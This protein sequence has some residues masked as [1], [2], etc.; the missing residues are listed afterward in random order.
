M[1]I[2]ET[3]DAGRKWLFQTGGI[4]A[5]ALAI[6]YLVIMALYVPIGAPPGG[7][8]ARLAYFARNTAAWWGI[9]GLSVFTDFLFVPVGLSLYAALKG[10]NRNAM[11]LAMAC[12]ALFVFLDLAIT[13]INYG[14]MIALSGDYAKAATDEQR[15]AILPAASYPAAVL[16][17]S[18]LFVYNTLTLAV[19]ILLTGIVM[20][21]GVFG[22]PTAYLAVATGILGLIS[23]AGPFF[24]PALSGT[25]IVTSL[26]TTVWIFCVGYRLWKLA[27]A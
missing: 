20:R 8:E 26:C 22:R 15:A 23:V 25:I 9:L 27:G 2:A 6:A 5:L 1:T 7:V 24:V 4:S 17:S 21:R 18:L 11:V 12:I 16:D 14:A 3:Q 13:W 19:G 10:I